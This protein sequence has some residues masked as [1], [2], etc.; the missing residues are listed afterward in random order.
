MLPNFIPLREYAGSY[1]GEEV[2]VKLSV[3]LNC[4]HQ[5][6]MEWDCYRLIDFPYKLLN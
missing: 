3:H 5:V 4:L 2:F 6:F 1:S